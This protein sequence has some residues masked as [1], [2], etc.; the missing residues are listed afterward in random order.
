MARCAPA[1][2]PKPKHNVAPHP[3][4]NGF[5]S[6]IWHPEVFL[7]CAW[8]GSFGSGAK[9][10][11]EARVST[12]KWG[13]TPITR[14]KG[15]IVHFQLLNLVLVLVVCGKS[16]NTGFLYRLEIT[17]WNSSCFFIIVL[18][19]SWNVQNKMRSSSEI[20]HK[21]FSFL[22]KWQRKVTPDILTTRSNQWSW[23]ESFKAN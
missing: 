6:S 16:L 2:L 21:I 3:W 4:Q 9:A 10:T 19:T 22:Q 15:C 23:L 5:S 13:F 12:T 7:L 17:N 11:D 18:W 8:C 14:K 1:L 20:F